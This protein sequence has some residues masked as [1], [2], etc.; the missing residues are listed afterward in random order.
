MAKKKA[1][2]SPTRASD[3][4]FI[5]LP[6]PVARRAPA[7]GGKLGQVAEVARDRRVDGLATSEPIATADLE[8]L[9]RAFAILE[10]ER[11]Q[12]LGIGHGPC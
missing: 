3:T 11:E 6:R 7:A 8:R 10:R 5:G 2:T 1:A 9:G 12:C 4:G